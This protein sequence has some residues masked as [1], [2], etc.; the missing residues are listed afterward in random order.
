MGMNLQ[1]RRRAIEAEQQTGDLVR[2][3]IAEA[4]V[5]RRLEIGGVV[6]ARGSVLPRDIV[7]AIAPRNLRAMV[8]N[9]F[10]EIHLERK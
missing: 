5:L 4:T 9:H 2:D 10:L 7:M 1:Q 3:Y 6:F 8:T